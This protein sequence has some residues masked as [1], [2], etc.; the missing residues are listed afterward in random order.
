MGKNTGGSRPYISRIQRRMFFLSFA[1]AFAASFTQTLAV[2]VDNVIV[3]AF[4]G[5]TEV[6]AVSL[7]GPFFYLLEIPAA[8]LA[9]GI[10]TVSAKKIGAGQ[11]DQVNRQFCQVFFLSSIVLTVLTALSFLSVPRMAVLFGAR[12][13]AAGLQPFAAQYLYGLSFEIIPYV[14]FCILMPVVILD[15]GGRIVS[16]ASACGCITDIV[17]DLL[18]VRFGWGLF[19]IGLAS[20]ASALV[21]FGITMLHFLNRDRVIRLRFVR[22]CAGELKDII[23][24]SAPKAFLALS[25]TICSLL[26]IFLASATG[27]VIGVFALSVHTTITYTIKIF[28]SGLAGAVG[29]MAG[30]SCGEK[31]GEDLEGTG[32]LA[33]RYI[34]LVSVCLMA[35]AAV[36]ARP[37]SAILA[38]SEASAALL[39][40]TFFCIIISIPFSNLVHVRISYL[41]AVG[42]VREARLMGIT[43][44]LAF[45][46]L[47]ACLIAASF[48]VRGVF[49][50]FPLSQILTLLASWFV[51]WKRTKQV[52]PSK[53]DYIEAD[54]SFYPG[55][56]D[57]ISYPV[58]TKDDCTL[59]AEQVSLFCRG[60]KLDDRKAYLAGLCVEEMTVNV[61]EHGLN[62][63]RSVRA[64]DLR[65]VI[66]GND[67]IIRLRDGGAPFNL[68]RFADHLSGENVSKSGPGIRIL[69]NSAKNI[70]YYRTYGMNTTIIKI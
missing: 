55:P 67:V 44:S 29:I 51:H 2:L 11:I 48:G 46:A 19:G 38:E 62:S 60:H 59:S 27:G 35:A 16:A 24:F 52:V 70:D 45:P 25:D 30:I 15:N 32:I 53:S 13:A 68:K 17:L 61:V 22:I 6:A 21:Y 50:A 57:V 5:E 12:G 56:G 31:N 40:F 36:C 26:F 14:L 20:S 43:A 33:H 66:D 34:L 3:C 47:T 18:S 39:E 42:C 69:L 63:R 4:F 1:T 49:T 58:I 23:I 37:L 65:V 54:A 28:T 10:Q 9:A 8:G 41:Q 64:M 7:A